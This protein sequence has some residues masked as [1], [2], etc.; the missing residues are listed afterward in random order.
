MHGMAIQ[1]RREFDIAAGIGSIGARL[2]G[3]R[4]KVAAAALQ[5]AQQTWAEEQERRSTSRRRA[6]AKPKP[7]SRRPR[8]RRSRPAPEAVASARR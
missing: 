5:E 6:K 8:P 2:S 3:K 4:H 7:G 1:F